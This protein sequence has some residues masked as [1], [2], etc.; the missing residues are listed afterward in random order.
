MRE[1]WPL[2]SRSFLATFAGGAVGWSAL[3]AGLSWGLALG[4]AVTLVAIGLCSWQRRVLELRFMLAFVPAF[5]LLTW[6]ALYLGVGLV[7]YW[8]TGQTLGGE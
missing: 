7:R 1:R 8:L 6:P 5:A 2:L 3:F 4:V